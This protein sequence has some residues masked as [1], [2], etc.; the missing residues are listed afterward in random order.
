MFGKCC[1]QN[2]RLPFNRDEPGAVMI[3]VAVFLYYVWFSMEKEKNVEM[4][5]NIK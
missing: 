1:I 3:E 4:H 5:L 2:V